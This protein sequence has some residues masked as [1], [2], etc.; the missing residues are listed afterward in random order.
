[1]TICLF[2]IEMLEN[3]IYRTS[4]NFSFQTLP[5]T[6]QFYCFDFP[7]ANMRFFLFFFMWAGIWV[8]F[9]FQFFRLKPENEI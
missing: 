7:R 9:L 5:H 3:M 2:A 6:F 1:M 8:S 4:Y